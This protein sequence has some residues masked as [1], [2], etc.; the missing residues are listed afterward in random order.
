MAD[1]GKETKFKKWLKK[2]VGEPPVLYDP[3]LTKKSSLQLKIYLENVGYFNSIVTDTVLL[4]NKKA[5][6]IYTVKTDVPYKIDT[7]RYNIHDSALAR[8]ITGDS[9]FRLFKTGD[10]FNG[11][12][13]G[14]ERDRIT[15]ILNDSGYFKFKSKYIR[16]WIDSAFKNHTVNVRLDIE[17][18]EIREID[19]NKIDLYHQKYYINNIFV[20]STFRMINLDSTYVEVPFR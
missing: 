8:I 12:V 2:T 13:L 10:I 7:I 4:S 6:I 15:K 16:F 19:T 11:N 20:N 18:P 14:Q 1:R 9:P 3:I 17:N 5:H